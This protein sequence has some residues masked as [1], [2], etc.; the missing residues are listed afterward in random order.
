MLAS[1][2]DVVPEIVAQS[3]YGQKRQFFG[4]QRMGRIRITVPESRLKPGE[5]DAALCL[6]LPF[7][8]FVILAK[9]RISHQPGTRTAGDP[10]LRGDDGGIK[11]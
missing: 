6:F 7:F 3:Q 9:A 2:H 4:L 10:L 5:G 8:I 11:G 1:P